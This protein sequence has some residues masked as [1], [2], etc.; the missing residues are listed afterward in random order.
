MTPA[1]SN[2]YTDIADLSEDQ[3]IE[4]FPNPV[5]DFLDIRLLNLP[6]TGLN[7]SIIDQL[8]RERINQMLDGS[9]GRVDVSFLV[10][11]F[12]IIRVSLD[13]ETYIYKILRLQ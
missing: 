10:P 12:Y 7:I 13:K 9:G 2:I 4:I 8:G 6:A 1:E 11:G 5:K 3:N